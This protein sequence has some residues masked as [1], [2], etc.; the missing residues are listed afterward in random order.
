M[1]D[2]N[3]ILLDDFDWKYVGVSK[4]DVVKK[5]NSTEL[6]VLSENVYTM[7][8]IDNCGKSIFT[9]KEILEKLEIHYDTIYYQIVPGTELVKFN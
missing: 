5:I 1:V 2:Y 6:K 9:V 4:Q 7:I 3:I 8:I